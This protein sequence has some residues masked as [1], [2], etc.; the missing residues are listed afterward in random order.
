MVLITILFCRNQ[1]LKENIKLLGVENVWN[2]HKGLSEFIELA[3]VLPSKYVITLIGLSDTQIKTLSC[4]TR[5]IPRDNSVNELVWYYQ[6]SGI[7]LKLSVK[8]IMRLTTIEA[9]ACG[10]RLLYMIKQQF[11]K[12]SIKIGE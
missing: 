8:E 12:S 11:L 4:N 9:L 10:D 2:D 7:H 3:K 1:E 5:G 6:Q